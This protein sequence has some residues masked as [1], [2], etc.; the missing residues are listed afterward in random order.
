VI[1]SPGLGNIKSA[2]FQRR[3]RGERNAAAVLGQGRGSNRVLVTV[4]DVVSIGATPLNRREVSRNGSSQNPTLAELESLGYEELQKAQ[5]REQAN[6]RPMMTEGRFYGV[7]YF[8]GDSVT[9]RGRGGDY[10]KRIIAVTATVEGN[11][12]QIELE[13]GDVL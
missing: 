12:E 8:F 1:F 11:G 13:F 9:Y 5:Y 6:F 3:R 7:D 2:S 4:E 10:H